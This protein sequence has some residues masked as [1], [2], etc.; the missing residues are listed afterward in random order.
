[1][2]RLA[3]LIVC[4]GLSR[5]FADPPAPD[6]AP[7]SP[8]APAPTEEIPAPKPRPKKSVPAD[9]VGVQTPWYTG[10]NATNRFIHLAITGAFALYDVSGYVFPSTALTPT[11]CRWC[12]PPSF[13]RSARNALVWSNTGRANTLSTVGAYVL[14]PVVG[15]TLL[16]ASDKNASAT[17]LIDDV[18]PVAETVAIVQVA[19]IFGKYLVARERPNAYFATGP[20]DPKAD[21]YSSFWS[22]HSVLGFAITSA[23]GTVC[24]ERRYWTEPYVWTAGIALSLSVEYLRMAADQHYLSDVVTGGLIGLGAGLLVPRLMDRSVQIVPM[25]NGVSVVAAF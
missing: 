24:H 19:T 10:P 16:I 15:L 18:L 12:T 20:L 13:D 4:L 8:S 2:H 21:N 7:T 3:I 1:V 6:P 17:R 5:S 23:A 9:P 14:A 22:G 25:P 11:S